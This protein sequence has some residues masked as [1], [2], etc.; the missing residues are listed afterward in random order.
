M[1]MQRFIEILNGI[2]DTVIVTLLVFNFESGDYVHN[3]VSCYQGVDIGMSRVTRA[4]V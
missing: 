4:Q 1:V 3:H 2:P